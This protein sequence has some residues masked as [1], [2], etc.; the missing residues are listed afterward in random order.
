M[1]NSIENNVSLDL[2]KRI[3]CGFSN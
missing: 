2:S 1:L 3:V